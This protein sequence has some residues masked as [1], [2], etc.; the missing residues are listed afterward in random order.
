[1]AAEYPYSTIENVFGKTLVEIVDGKGR[2]SYFNE[3]DWQKAERHEQGIIIGL[4]AYLKGQRKVE[5][6]IKN[7]Y[8][9]KYPYWTIWVELK[10]PPPI[11]HASEKR[12]LEKHHIFWQFRKYYKPEFTEVECV[13]KRFPKR[14]F[15]NYE[16]KCK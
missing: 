11:I 4:C 9:L 1:M 8:K 6:D 14:Q 15:R 16:M 3:W 7:K 2:F 5:E 12:L 10:V 13:F